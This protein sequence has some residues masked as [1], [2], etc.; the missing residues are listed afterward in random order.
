MK[1]YEVT[2]KWNKQFVKKIYVADNPDDAIHKS[3]LDIKNCAI[4]AWNEYKKKPFSY[5]TLI[6]TMDDTILNLHNVVNVRELN[7]NEN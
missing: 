3:K 6:N 1:K 4:I 2:I 7:E 5:E